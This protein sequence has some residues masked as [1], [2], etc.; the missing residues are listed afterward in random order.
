MKKTILSTLMVLAMAQPA[1]ALTLKELGALKAPYSLAAL[2][3]ATD[4]FVPIIDKQTMELHHGKHHQAY[5]DNLNKLVAEQKDNFNLEKLLA[6]ASKTEMGIRNNAG[7]HWNHTFF[8]SVLTND[9]EKQKMPERLKTEIEKTFGSIDTFKEAFEKAGLSQFGSGWA[10]L[11]RDNKGKLVITSTPNQDNPLMDVVK[12]KGKPILA[13]D[14]WE[15]A[16]YLNY[17]N[18]RAE[19]MKKIWS[20]IN[21]SQVNDFDLE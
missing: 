4:A 2:P 16:Y 17:Q 1:M 12:V 10:W 5:V 3:Y 14:V 15:H 11:I 18:K 6:R 21:W 19:Y 8:W 20:I 9:Q 13:V 7:G